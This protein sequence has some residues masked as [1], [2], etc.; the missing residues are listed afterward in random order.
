MAR[1]FFAKLN[2]VRERLVEGEGVVATGIIHWGI[3][4]R[5]IAVFVLAIFFALFI[6]VELGIFLALVSVIAGIYAVLKKEI[7]LL[8]VTDKR[9]LVRFGLLQVDVVDIHFDKIE[10]IEL[11]RMWLGYLLGYSNVVIMGTG[12]RY[13][14]IPYVANGVQ[15][16]QAYNEMT[17]SA[18]PPP[19]S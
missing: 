17:L 4:W 2:D 1:Q 14:E 9:V 3:Y 8:V 12:N 10:S 7:L 18:K 19:V 11:R 16:R 13:I 15:I 5:A 6:A